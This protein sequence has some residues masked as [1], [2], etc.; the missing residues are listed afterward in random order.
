MS[1]KDSLGDRMKQYE[2]AT[3][4]QYFMPGLPLYARLDGR[5]FHTFTRG[6]GKPYPGARNVDFSFFNLMALLC[7]ALVKETN[8]DLGYVQSDE[9]SL[10]WKDVK[11][12]P[13]DGRKFKIESVFASLAGAHFM[14]LIHQ[15]D[16]E[17]FKEIQKRAALHVPCFDC[18]VFQLPN[19][20]ELAN[21]FV[22][23]END[24]IKNSISSYAME[25]F[26][27]KE[28]HG[29]DQKDRLEMLRDMGKPWECLLPQ[30]RRGNYYARVN[31][32]IEGQNGEKAVRSKISNVLTFHNQL[33]KIENRSAAL[34]RL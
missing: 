26:S 15:P 18:R 33:A 8:A 2:A 5:A 19:L 29:K 17:L 11:T 14:R 12:A 10:G 24:A 30:I 13:F 16:E 4:E 21:V 22:W 34:I 3:T 9:I 28:L 31:Y 20:V 1:D 6:L 25:F 7:Q 23:R 27:D 32:E